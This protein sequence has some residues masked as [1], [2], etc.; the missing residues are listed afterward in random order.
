MKDDKLFEKIKEF[1]RLH[2]PSIIAISVLLFILLYA[3]DKF[4]ATF[5]SLAQICTGIGAIVALWNNLTQLQKQNQL[6]EE[7]LRIKKYRKEFVKFAEWLNNTYGYD[8]IGFRRNVECPP[9]QPII[10]EM[11]EMEKNKYNDKNAEQFIE[12]Y[13]QI[14]E[15]YKNI[16]ELTNIIYRGQYDDE[17][18]ELNEDK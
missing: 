5:T 8:N 9:Y 6:Q 1:Y 10:F 4:R 7:H 17:L 18:K 16:F 11:V 15:K 2:K 13:F 14:M 12:L 3:N